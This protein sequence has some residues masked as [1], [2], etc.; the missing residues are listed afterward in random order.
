MALDTG[1][2]DLRRRLPL[3]PD[4]LWTLLTDPRHRER[5]GAPS[6]GTVL[7]MEREDLRVGGVERHRCG[8]E[9]APEFSVETRWYHLAGPERAVFTETVEAGGMTLFT[10]LVTY[11]LEAAGTGTELG[12]TVAV[13]S[14]TGPEALADIRAGWEGGLANLDRHVAD[15][16]R[17]TQG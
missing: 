7:V 10:S 15:Q 13:S 1:S 11:L 3:P 17:E 6:E 4:R 9:E 14:F 5:W 16:A 2:F 12:V 8:P